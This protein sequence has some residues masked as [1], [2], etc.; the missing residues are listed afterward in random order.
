L[1]LSANASVPSRAAPGFANGT[2]SHAIAVDHN[3]TRA[4]A[5]AGLRDHGAR[6]RSGANGIACAAEARAKPNTA[7]AIVLIIVSS[8]QNSFA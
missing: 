3:H 7:I 6:L 4:T 1:P 5:H 8:S 2:P